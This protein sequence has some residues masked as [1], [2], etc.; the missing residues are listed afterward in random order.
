LQA[1]ADGKVGLILSVEN[2]SEAAGVAEHG[3]FPMRNLRGDEL[4]GRT[5]QNCA[6][7]NRLGKG[8][9]PGE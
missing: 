6:P 2:A 5:G 4:P 8:V 3:F 7:Q 9:W 1:R